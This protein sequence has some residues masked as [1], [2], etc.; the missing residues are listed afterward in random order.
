MDV[1]LIAALTLVASAVGTLTGFGTSTI[2]VPILDSFY[3]LP[4]SLFLVGI[5]HWFGDIWKMLLF[6]S[7]VRWRLV[8]LFGVAGIVATVLFRSGVRWRLVV[9]FGVAGIVATVLGSLL[10]FRAP[11][12]LLSRTLGA[13]LLAYVGFVFVKGRF[14]IPQTTATALAGAGFMACRP[15]SSASDVYIFTAGAIGLVVDSGRLVTYWWEGA[16]L[17]A[18]LWWRVGGMP[19]R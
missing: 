11:E 17:S 14:A 19:R 8:V 1:A 18:A 7:G 2:M 12:E 3:P 13:F 16:Q 4:Q 5:I 10:V 15:G 6:R 9:L